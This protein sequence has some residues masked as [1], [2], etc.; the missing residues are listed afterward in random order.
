APLPE[1]K[2]FLL[3]IIG[4]DDP[5][6]IGLKSFDSILIQELRTVIWVRFDLYT[7]RMKKQIVNLVENGKRFNFTT[8]MGF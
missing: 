1:E 4:K 3:K 6:S 8:K 5:K 2:D 7:I